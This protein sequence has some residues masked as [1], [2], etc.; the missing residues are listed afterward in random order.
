MRKEKAA[1]YERVSTRLAGMCGL[2]RPPIRIEGFDISNLSG[3]GAVGSMVT[4][5]EGR[6]AKKYYRKFAIR[7]IEGQ[8]DFAMMQQVVRRR[9]GHGEDFGGMPDLLLID[10]GKGQLGAAMAALAEAGHAS[11][12]AISLAKERSREGETIFV[13]RIFLPGRKNPV[14]PPKNDPV[15]LLLMRIRDES[16]RFA[17][18]FQRARRTKAAFSAE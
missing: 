8:N 4:F 17:V 12:P 18:T 13:E 5:V 10:G 7:D 15:L 3:T 6:A 1:S 9:F 14:V 16:H 11:V 2:P